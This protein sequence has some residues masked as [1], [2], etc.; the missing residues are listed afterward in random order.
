MKYALLLL[1]S[2]V[3]T[4][5]ACENHLATRLI[6]LPTEKWC[7]NKFDN[8]KKVAPE[9]LSMSEILEKCRLTVEDF[10][11]PVG[12]E[13]IGLDEE[14]ISSFALRGLP[15]S[16]EYLIDAKTVER[17]INSPENST[18]LA[19]KYIKLACYCDKG[20]NLLNRPDVNGE[21]PL[22]KC[23]SRLENC[24]DAE[25]NHVESL[26]KAF[27]DCGAKFHVKQPKIS[28]SKL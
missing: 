4:A 16:F 13:I 19:V 27:H 12:K 11:G 3:I 17:I 28:K 5:Y 8:K 1:F 22:E 6:G 23:Y 10:I 25:W 21:T 24:E 20:R 14:N 18:E 2:F 7:K 9:S 26:I 15:D